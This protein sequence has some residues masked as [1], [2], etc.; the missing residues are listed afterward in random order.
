MA[1]TYR[2][3]TGRRILNRLMR[4]LLRLGLAPRTTYLLTV[5][6]RRTGMPYST[7]VTLVVDAG[8]WLVAPYGPGGW[9]RNARAA[10]HVTLSRGRRSEVVRIIELGP[11][12]AA[13]VLQRYVV[14]VPITRPYF[15]VGPESPLAAF[16]AEAPRHPVF[17]IL[18]SEKVRQ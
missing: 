10:G 16:V 6:G 12:E 18:G 2:L 3:T 9:V 11:E 15:D 5:R 14:R 1:K 13:P 7:P 4:G 17:R 8:R